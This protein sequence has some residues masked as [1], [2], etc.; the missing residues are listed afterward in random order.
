MSKKESGIICYIAALE[1]S[2]VVVGLLD[3]F[4]LLIVSLENHLGICYQKK[5]RKEGNRMSTRH[6]GTY[7]LVDFGGFPVKKPS[8]APLGLALLDDFLGL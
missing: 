5:E 1:F 4:L 6:G 7:F 3:Y 2:L 8:M